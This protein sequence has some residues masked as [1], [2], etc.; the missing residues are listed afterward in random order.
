MFIFQALKNTYR[1]G[2]AYKENLEE[3]GYAVDMISIDNHKKQ[4]EGYDLLVLG[5]PTYSKVAAKDLIQFISTNISKSNNPNAKAMTFITHSWDTAY[6]HISLA[7]ALEK[8]D[9]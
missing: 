5:S 3:L 7:N 9:F 6:G 2:E 8:A 1:I 4:L